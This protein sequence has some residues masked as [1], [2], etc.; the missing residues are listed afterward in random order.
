MGINIDL[1]LQK[2]Q[3]QKTQQSQPGNHKS[4]VELQKEQ[5][6]QSS[7][8]AQ[9]E[10]ASLTN[11]SL[12]SNTIQN[13]IK[14]SNGSANLNELMG[15]YL[16]QT[17]KAA[18]AK[19][20]NGNAVNV[21]DLS[22]NDMTAVANGT[23]PIQ[24]TNTTQNAKAQNS[25]SAFGSMT[26]KTSSNQS[27]TQKLENQ[28][29][30]EYKN[31]KEK[32]TQDKNADDKLDST[33]VSKAADGFLKLTTGVNSDI[34]ANNLMK[35]VG[36]I[37]SANTTAKAINSKQSTGDHIQENLHAKGIVKDVN[38]KADVDA[39]IDEADKS[40]L[41]ELESSCFE[42][43]D[44]AKEAEDSAEDN[45][46]AGE[47]QS[48]EA[49]N[50]ESENK[51]EQSRLENKSKNTQA[52][53]KAQ[54]NTAKKSIAHDKQ[55]LQ[56]AKSSA[57]KNKANVGSHNVSKG[58]SSTGTAAGSTA[59]SSTPTAKEVNSNAGEVSQFETQA[60][61]KAQA[62]KVQD[63]QESQMKD[64]QKEQQDKIQG[65]QEKKANEQK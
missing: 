2:L 54:K 43:L 23:N 8:F 29:Q 26:S 6:Q 27:Q 59:A 32:Y 11:E 40:D 52:K 15:L 18:N 53:G 4:L 5:A 57:S 39:D 48:N 64:Q 25:K 47:K 42:V 21:S 10:L 16:N 58:N 34:D 44:S 55:A 62:E 41:N 63:K 3:T 9:Q 31:N 19:D 1:I 28:I 20:S 46:D 36:Q 33:K 50:S 49:K 7:I 56:R 38:F 51:S 65:E 45:T 17:G 30:N 61:Q 13:V 12:Y 14:S 24:K 22:L 37:T 35:L 60:M